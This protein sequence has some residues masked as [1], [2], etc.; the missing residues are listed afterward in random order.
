MKYYQQISLMP[1]ADIG[2]YFLWQKVYQQIHLALVENKSSDNVSAIG[3][4]FPEYNTNRYSP[5]KR[6]K[7]IM[8]E[9]AVHMEGINNYGMRLITMKEE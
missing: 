9:D 4:S 6:N 8:R 3:V 7:P 2:L 1:T 5:F